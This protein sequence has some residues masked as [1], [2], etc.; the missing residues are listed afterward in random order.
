MEKINLQIKEIADK[1]GKKPVFGKGAERAE[2]LLL[3]EAPGAKEEETGIPFAGSAGKNLDEFL[4]ILGLSR[5][6]LYITNTVKVRP[7]KINE[8]TGRTVNRPPT[9]REIELFYP[10]LRK[11]I[12]RVSPKIIVTLGN[13]PL[14][15]LLGKDKT[16]GSCH[17]ILTSWEGFPLFPLYHP[18]AV[19]YR[20]S[21]KSEYLADLEGLK[22][23]LDGK[24]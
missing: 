1:L 8:K 21:L 20:Q 17:G 15:T 7:S 24:M 16:I 4:G 22:S 23:F 3:G 6:N 10:V 11:E 9:E 2:I 13:T 5:D 12:F 14:K 19:I 18:A